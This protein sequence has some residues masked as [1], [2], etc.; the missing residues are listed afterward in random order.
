MADKLLEEVKSEVKAAEAKVS[1]VAAEVKAEVENVHPGRIWN[2]FEEF[3]QDY[4][5]K[6]GINK[7]WLKTVKMHVKDLGCLKNQ[8]KWLECL[9]HFGI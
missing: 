7:A 8:A 1:A 9:K 5:N 2:S 6:H 3:Y 4:A